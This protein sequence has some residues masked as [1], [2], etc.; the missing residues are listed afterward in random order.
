MFWEKRHINTTTYR[1]GMLQ[2]QAYRAL[3]N[4]LTEALKPHGI[5]MTGW[6]TLGTLRDQPELR[7]TEIA[8]ILNV[9]PPVVTTM[10]RDLEKRGL[11]ERQAQSGDNRVTKLT[12][13]DPGQDLVDRVEL[14]LRKSLREYLVDVPINELVIYLRVIEK[15]AAKL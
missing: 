10:V 13:T 7:L 15:L 12:L 3:S 1:A 14:E 4:F 5:T 9:K 11:V 8:E 2:S 6:A